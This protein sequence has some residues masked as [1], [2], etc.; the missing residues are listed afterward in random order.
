MELRDLPVVVVD[1]QSRG[2]DFWSKQALKKRGAV[3]AIPGLARRRGLGALQ[4]FAGC[5]TL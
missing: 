5:L 2:G 1:G 3:Q 4:T